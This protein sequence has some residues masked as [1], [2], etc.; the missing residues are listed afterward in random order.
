MSGYKQACQFW[1]KPTQLR[2]LARS[3]ENIRERAEAGKEGLCCIPGP[4]KL[5]IAPELLGDV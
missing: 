2:M 3:E 1:A 4:E 5:D